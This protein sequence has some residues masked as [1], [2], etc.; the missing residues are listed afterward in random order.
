M[1]SFNGQLKDWQVKVKCKLCDDTIWSTY[2]G[3]FIRCKCGA[4]F[5]DQTPYYSRYGGNR[6]DMVFL[7]TE[8]ENKQ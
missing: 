5:C 7:P 1:E 8:K 3:E 2:D 4:I 6:G